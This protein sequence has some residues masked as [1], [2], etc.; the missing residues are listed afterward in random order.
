MRARRRSLARLA[1]G[2]DEKR[3]HERFRH[4]WRVMQRLERR[5]RAR[6]DAETTDGSGA[7]LGVVDRARE[8]MRDAMRAMDEASS[9]GS[10]R[11]ARARDDDDARETGR[12][13][14]ATE[15]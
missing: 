5:R 6:D 11:R 9:A 7:P 4:R 10:R 3:A 12:R 14:R 13:A 1:P 15:A 8:A 2:F